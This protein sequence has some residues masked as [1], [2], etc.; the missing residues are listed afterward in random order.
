M[1]LLKTHLLLLL[2][3]L[4]CNHN[5]VAQSTTRAPS[6]T[7]SGAAILLSSVKDKTAPPADVREKIVAANR[8]MVETFKRGDLRGVAAFYADDAMIFS[9]RG[10][11]IQGRAAIDQ[12]WTNIKNAKDWKLEVIE[13]GGDK[14]SVWQI[15]K[16]SL[17][18]T[19][20]GADQ[21][22]VCDFVVLWKRQADGTYKIY[23]DIYN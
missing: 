5:A 22:Y 7:S 6:Q 2:F 14:E 23:V 13:L 17:T 15:G 4:T 12:Y 16:S 20:N 3:V 1:R 10:K 11:K 9:H 19:Y 8:Q 21:T 18:T